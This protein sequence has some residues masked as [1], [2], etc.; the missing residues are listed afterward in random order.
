VTPAAEKDMGN[1][2]LCLEDGAHHARQMLINGED[3]LK[4]VEHDG[5]GAA[6]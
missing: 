1:V 6:R 5:D 4:L 2:A 3:F